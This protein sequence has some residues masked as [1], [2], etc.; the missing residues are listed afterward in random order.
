M[1]DILFQQLLDIAP[2]PP[3]LAVPVM[4]RPLVGLRNNFI[5]CSRELNIPP[6]NNYH[7][8]GFGLAVQ[9]VNIDTIPILSEYG[10]SSMML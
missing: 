3:I 8:F 10:S 4:R 2:P 9:P 7:T 5:G 6:N 1:E